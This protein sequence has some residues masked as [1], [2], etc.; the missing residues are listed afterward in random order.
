MRAGGSPPTIGRGMARS[1]IAQGVPPPGGRPLFRRPATRAG[2]RAV[3]IVAGGVALIVLA[4]A[5]VRIVFHEITGP[6]SLV[7]VAAILV[8]GVLGAVA[9]ARR[10]E[11]SI[12]V[13]AAVGLWVL[14][15]LFVI[16]ELAR[17]N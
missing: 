12:L 11:R 7:G 6:V 17:T 15:V 2:R 3:W 5:V 4:A 13:Y 16:G 9:V 8:G 10:R 14:L 1:V